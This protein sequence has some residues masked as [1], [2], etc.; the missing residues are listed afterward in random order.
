[1]RMQG[2]AVPA[3]SVVEM[4]V[5]Q[6]QVPTARLTL[7]GVAISDLNENYVSD[8]RSEIVPLNSAV[9]GLWKSQS[10]WPLG[11]RILSQYPL[12]YLRV[13]FPTAGRST[14]IM[15]GIREGLR[16]LRPS[17]SKPEPTERAVVVS[18]NN[19]HNENITT[20]PE[21]RMVR[22]IGDLRASAGGKFEFNGPKRDALFRFMKRGGDLG[23][24]VVLVLPLSPVYQREFVT[25]EVT[26]RFEELLSAAKKASPDTLW[27]RLDAAP[28]L[29]SNELYWDLVHLNA[30]GQA[31]ASRLVREQLT[32]AGIR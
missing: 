20:W 7:L 15:V 26:T 27:I 10:S 17:K 3:G 21:D 14:S 25:K 24:T 5:L 13:L 18:E 11:R 19:T 29:Q 28:E 4:E 9:T 31:I 8:F 16:A 30:L 23:K 1:M 32:A 6:A 12:S 2:W 22:N